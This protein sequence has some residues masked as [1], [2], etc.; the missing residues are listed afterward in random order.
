MKEKKDRPRLTLVK[1][2]RYSCLVCFIFLCVLLLLEV[3]ARHIPA[4]PKFRRWQFF[5]LFSLDRWDYLSAAWSKLRLE[6]VMEN[7]GF[8]HYV[9]EPE[10]D[11]PPFDHIPYPFDVHTNEFGFRDHSFDP[12]EQPTFVLLGD[13]VSFGK[14]GQVDE[15]YS[16]ILEKELSIR[17][18]NMSL[19]G[20]TAECMAI[21]WRNYH[22]LIEVD[23]LIIQGSGNDID[24]A[25]WK[26]AIST[27]TLPY[28]Q[29]ALSW[30]SHTHLFQ[31]LLFLMDD[32]R[33]AHQ[34]SK[35]V[36]LAHD[37]Y[38]P[39]L[40]HI[41]SLAQQRQLPVLFVHL[42]YAYGYFY[43]EHLSALCK[44][45]S[46]CTEIRP[47]FEVPENIQTHLRAHTSLNTP[48]EHFISR[49]HK[50]FPFSKEELHAIFPLHAYF[51]DVVHLNSIGHYA[52]AQSL[53]TYLTN[54]TH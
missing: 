7:P 34:L 48:H 31:R 23:G 52:V 29:K 33:M 17:I 15:R 43:A 12:T 16:N 36:E 50:E 24:Q 8:E 6:T 5:I 45:Y 18:Y 49:T 38:Q 2:I 28:S 53:K 35:H 32:Q 3:T 30:L 21:I 51:H 25:G 22:Q 14:G 42:P 26:E 1:K 46:R 27:T 44:K 10:Q 13:S 19:Q 39:N 11:R 40:I 20:C 47:A 41:L 54:H 9:E 4:S 37:H